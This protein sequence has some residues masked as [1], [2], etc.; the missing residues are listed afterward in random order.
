[1]QH[2]SLALI[3]KYLVQNR[4]TTLTLTQKELSG[5]ASTREVVF[6]FI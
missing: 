2:L 6:L 4:G 1:M 5:S 3:H